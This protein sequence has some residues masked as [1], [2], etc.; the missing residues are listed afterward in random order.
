MKRD[1]VLKKILKVGTEITRRYYD[2]NTIT[3]IIV[4]KKGGLNYKVKW[5]L[6]NGNFSHQTVNLSAVVL[7]S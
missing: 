5:N 1:E 7:S 4:E 2:G 3:G 6:G